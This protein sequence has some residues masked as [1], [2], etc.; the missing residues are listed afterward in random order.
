MAINWGAVGKRVSGAI[1]AG[2]GV[3]AGGD[4]GS[5]S[6][7]SS[8]S[9]GRKVGTAIRSGISKYRKKRSGGRKPVSPIKLGSQKAM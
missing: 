2:A 4:S 3:Y 9:I 6:N 8:S 1:K 5:S 7:S